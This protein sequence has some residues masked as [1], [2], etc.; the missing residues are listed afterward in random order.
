MRQN[1]C[2]QEDESRLITAEA[3]QRLIVY[4]CCTSAAAGRLPA[5]GTAPILLHSCFPYF[6]TVC[7][8]AIAAQL[9][10][11]HI[12]SKSREAFSSFTLAAATLLTAATAPYAASTRSCF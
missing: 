3:A 7:R 4:Y 6:A 9:P 5:T 12:V 1:K 10:F 2:K 11:K 8:V